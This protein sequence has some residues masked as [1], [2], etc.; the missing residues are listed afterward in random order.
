MAPTRHVCLVV[1]SHCMRKVQRCMQNPTDL[2]LYL[3]VSRT[4]ARVQSINEL[5]NAV[6]KQVFTG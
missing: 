5:T 1:V 4:S 3:R 6:V 2:A